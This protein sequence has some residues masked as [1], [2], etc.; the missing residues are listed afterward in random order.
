M[1]NLVTKISEKSGKTAKDI[2]SFLNAPS[3]SSAF[4]GFKDAKVQVR[5]TA[6]VISRHPLLVPLE[7]QVYAYIYNTTTGEL[8][9]SL[10]ET[11]DLFY[12]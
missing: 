8:L 9:R 2:L 7:I 11:S 12:D 3:V 6:R 5:K 10:Y 4:R 1:N